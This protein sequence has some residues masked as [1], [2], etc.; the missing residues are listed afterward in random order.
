MDCKVC[1]LHL[2][3]AFLKKRVDM[4]LSRGGN[5]EMEM[6]VLVRL[7]GDLKLTHAVRYAD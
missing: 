1:E 3:R 2:N 6:M 4:L 7:S 5:D